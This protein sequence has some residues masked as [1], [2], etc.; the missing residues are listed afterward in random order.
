[1][2]CADSFREERRG[3]RLDG[4]DLRRLWVRY[5]LAGH[6]TGIEATWRL[7]SALGLT[8]KTAPGSS[9]GFEL[10]PWQGYPSRRHRGLT[11]AMSALAVC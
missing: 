6:Y 10:H 5:L 1:M 8:R 7:R 4:G 2:L 3:G 11:Q 9:V